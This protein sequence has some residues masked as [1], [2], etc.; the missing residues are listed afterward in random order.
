MELKYT[1]QQKQVFSARQQ[2]SAAVLQM[3]RIELEEFLSQEVLEN[4]LLEYDENR[5]EDYEERDIVEKL[6]WL[7]ETDKQNLSYYEQDYDK[8]NDK[9]T[10]LPNSA[11]EGL[12]K[13]ILSQF[14]TMKLNKRKQKILEYLVLSLDERGYFTEEPHVTAEVLHTTEDEIEECLFLLKKAEPAGIGAKDLQECLLLQLDRK[15]LEA[16]V[17]RKIICS[18]LELLGKNQLSFLAKKLDIS[19]RELLENFRLIQELNP[20]PGNGFAY[21]EH[22]KYLKPDVTVVKFSDR[23]EII[24]N[25]ASTQVMVHS[26]Y[27]RMLKED[28]DLE[29]KEYI[30]KKLNQAK[31]TIQC[32]EQRSATLGAVAKAL[33]TMQT[34]FFESGKEYLVPLT[35]QQLAEM[36]GLHE[37]TVSRAVKDKY[38]QCSWGIYPVAYF[39][40]K[41]L[42]DHT[43]FSGT[44]LHAKERLKELT[45]QEN[46]RCPFS[47]QKLSELLKEKGVEISRRTVA[48]YREELGIPD[49]GKRKIFE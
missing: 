46:R 48:K 15:G 34:A 41:K 43:G 36:V 20:K 19:M 30:R 44:T 21:R 22:L 33:V 10:N 3:G 39:F 8:E 45:E 1:S 11:E 4:P 37:S 14:Y 18:Y 27:S 16:P 9:I 6:E 29:T 24:L 23:F 32:V 7:E 49:K 31:W 47:D 12:E 38:L 5:I 35:M 25:E 26:Y 42:K 2:Q 13:Y 28:V 17:A 40:V